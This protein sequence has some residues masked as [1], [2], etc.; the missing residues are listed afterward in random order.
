MIIKIIRSED[1]DESV[2]LFQHLIRVYSAVV[3]QRY[4]AHTPTED[5]F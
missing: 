3:I 1:H 2:F 4:F 5:A